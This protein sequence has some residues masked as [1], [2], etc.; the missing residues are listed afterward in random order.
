MHTT[1]IISNLHNVQAYY[2]QKNWICQALFLCY[3][4]KIFYVIVFANENMIEK[5]FAKKKLLFSCCNSI[6]MI[7]F[8]I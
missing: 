1:E 8:T 6:I 7:G 2:I 4:E 5:Q 3:F